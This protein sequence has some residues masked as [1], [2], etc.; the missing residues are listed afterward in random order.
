MRRRTAAALAATAAVAV[1]V[2]GCGGGSSGNKSGTTTGS[3][4]GNNKTV[5]VGTTDQP[6]VLD[7]AGAYDLPD[8]NIFYNTFQTLMAIPAGGNEPKPD[9]ATACSYENA[10]TYTCTLQ[11]GL[12]FANGD[13]LTAQDVKFSFDRMLKINDPNGPASLLASLK[14]TAVT[15]DKVTFTLSQADQT[16][17]YVIATGAGAIVDSKVFPADKLIANDKIV[18]SGPYKMVK[19]DAGQQ[20]VFEPNTN[21]TGPNKPQNGRVIE[22]FYS[23]PSALK[24]AIEQGN[25]DV[26]YRNLSPTD[27]KSLRGE[28]GVKV[29]EGAGSEIRYLTFD[30]TQGPGK[31]PAVRKAI[32]YLIDRNAIAKNV[33]N[34]TVDPLY[35]MIPSSL[36]FATEPF[37]D[38]Y[39]TSPDPAKAK[40]LLQA[41][42]VQTPVPITIWWTPTHYGAGSADEY[43][44]IKR[45][46][47][48]SG[49]FTVTLQS[50]EYAAY[51]KAYVKHQYEA[52]Q[53]GWFPDFPDADDYTLWYAKDGGFIHNGFDNATLQNL[54][55]QEKAEQDAS[56]RGEIFKQIQQIGAEQVPVLPIWQGKQ[57]GVVRSNVNGVEK[58]FDPSFTFRFWLISKS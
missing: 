4:S 58:T 46:L 13:P 45:Q 32:A 37:K 36:K 33:Y 2:A 18:G 38:M 1:A 17:P 35:S 51:K 5:I 39:G 8:W 3:G 6:S 14:S 56:K 7:P 22:Q 27:I 41:A 48:S 26:A 53:L 54:L 23:E 49:L 25:V 30:V 12:K 19:Y 16:F 47:D 44:E 52:W 9:A 11:T 42:G 57:I 50:T 21:Y 40:S 43:T 34:G 10:T 29:V 15:G 28:N 24:L 20:A 55:T 31:N